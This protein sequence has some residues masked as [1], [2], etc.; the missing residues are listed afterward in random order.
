MASV[1]VSTVHARIPAPIVRFQDRLAAVVGGGSEDRAPIIERMLARDTKESVA[2]WLQLGVSVGIATLGLALG[3]TAVVIAAMLVAPLMGPIIS[4]GMGL[5]TGGPYLTLRAVLR[6]AISVALVIAGSALLTMSLP[7]HELNVELSARTVPTALDLITAAFCAL[8]GVYATVRATSDTATTAAGTSIGISLV[9]PLCTAGFCLGTAQWSLAFGAGLLFLT[10]MVA[11]VVVGTVAFVALG[12]NQVPIAALEAGQ[13]GR[14]TGE[15]VVRG[16]ARGL[17]KVYAWRWGSWL[18]LLM[19]LVLLAMV[20]APLRSALDEVTWQVEVRTAARNLVDGLDA[21]VVASR[22]RVERHQV[23]AT[24]VII[25]SRADAEHL[26]ALLEADLARISGVIPR[27]GV[28]AVPA[29]TAVAV[30]RDRPLEPIAMAVP[31]E[32]FEARAGELHDEISE[33]VSA[34][35][36][37]ASAGEPLAIDVDVTA[38]GLALRVVHIGEPLDAAAREVLERSLT[39]DLGLSVSIHDEP[40]PA[41]PIEDI[42]TPARISDV[43]LLLARARRFSSVRACVQEPAPAAP[44]RADTPEQP[45]TDASAP[46]DDVRPVDAMDALPP[47]AEQIVRAMLDAHPRV[48]WS[49]GERWALWFVVGDCPG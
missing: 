5:A 39:L 8:A 10:N 47:E 3:S 27:V 42:D 17:A 14:A 12:F 20:Y 21:E 48:T 29:A 33:A 25:G 24:I 36:P 6:V 15:T 28:R 22:L 32:P 1:I 37:A 38:P 18:R 16:I 31:P 43:A 23:D 41:Q 35:W 9:P 30:E 7:F 26:Q 19:P 34:R 49:R 44:L 13:I 11:I 40:M 45:P 46:G 4:L 2:Y